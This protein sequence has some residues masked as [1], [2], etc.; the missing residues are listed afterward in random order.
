MYTE[1]VE[2]ILKQLVESQSSIKVDTKQD[3]SLLSI[4]ITVDSKDRGRII[5]REGQ[6][7]KALK[8]LLTALAPAGTQVVI[9][10]AHPSS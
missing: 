4:Y 8:G 5:G 6:T 1:L 9:D 2:Y 3:G 7:I 10:I